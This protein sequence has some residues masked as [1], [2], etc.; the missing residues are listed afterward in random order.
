MMIGCS[1]PKPM[2]VIPGG[3]PG[4]GKTS[5]ARALAGQIG[6]V[7]L[8]RDSKS[9]LDGLMETLRFFAEFSASRYLFMSILP[10]AALRHHN[11]GNRTQTPPFV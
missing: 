4:A 2:L 8:R 11:L 6:A 1:K 3:L 10:T 7:H 5:V 9:P